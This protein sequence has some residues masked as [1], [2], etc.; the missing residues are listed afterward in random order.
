MRVMQMRTGYWAID[1]HGCG[2]GAL[3]GGGDGLCAG[4]SR[5]CGVQKINEH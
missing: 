4:G 2:G 1:L 3:M 5:G